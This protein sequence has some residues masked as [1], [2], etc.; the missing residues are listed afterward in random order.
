[1]GEIILTIIVICAILLGVFFWIK[2]YLYP[3]SNLKAAIF[4]IPT[5]LTLG[6]FIFVYNYIKDILD[7]DAS[8]LDKFSSENYQSEYSKFIT[9]N[10]NSSGSSSN[11]ISK[12]LSNNS[13]NVNKPKKP[14]RSQT[15]ISGKTT[16]YDESG[17][18]MGDSYKDVS[19][20][21]VYYDEEGKYAGEGFDS[22]LGRTYY[23]DKDGNQSYSTTNNL[24]EQSFS[25]GTSTHSDNSGNTYYN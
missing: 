7:T 25:D 8:Y 15:D 20:R 16:Y 1:M 22:G 24:G 19:G 5:V 21:T 6:I 23:T 3:I 2:R 17:N 4:V 13:N 12:S 10:L 9:K 14:V 11:M 18:Y